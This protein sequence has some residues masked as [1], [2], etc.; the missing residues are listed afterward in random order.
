VSHAQAAISTA[1]ASVITRLPAGSQTSVQAGFVPRA[2]TS[3]HQARWDRPA[4][5]EPLGL[6][7]S[8]P[9]RGIVEWQQPGGASG[10]MVFR[11]S[12]VTSPDLDS[13]DFQRHESLT[14]GVDVDFRQ[15][16][17][18]WRLVGIEAGLG[19]EPPKLIFEPVFIAKVS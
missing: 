2:T 19:E 16:G 4:H 9:A 1:S 11:S 18:Q 17:T 8:R 10:P 7:R 5:I 13:E 3:L 12:F 6:F 15:E 14:L